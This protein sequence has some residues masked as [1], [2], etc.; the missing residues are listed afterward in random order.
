MSN[1]PIPHYI[2]PYKLVDRNITFSGNISLD[3]LPRLYEALATDKASICVDVVFQREQ[4]QQVLMSMTFNA[5]VELI[6]QRCLEVMSFTINKQYNYMFCHSKYE[7]M[8][9]P[10]GYDI[11]DVKLKDPFDLKTLIEDELLLAL[12]IIPMHTSD[13]CQQPAVITEPE[14]IENE[15]DR[16]NPFGILAQLKR[17]P[18]V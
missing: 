4:Q 12:P 9:L 6:C 1:D 2:E 11:L 3:S 17:D 7:Q 8:M 5:T 14:Q 16:S 10:D 18:K 13:E 15:S